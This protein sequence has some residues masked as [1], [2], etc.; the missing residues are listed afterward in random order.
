MGS[1][2]T[3]YDGMFSVREVPWHKHENAQVLS[4]YPSI[5]KARSI[6]HPWEPV[7]EE[8][9]RR[10]PY[11]ENGEPMS[12]FEKVE[13]FKLVSRSDNGLPLDAPPSD[14][15]LVLNKTLYEI[16]EAIEGEAKGSVQLETGGSL[17]AGKRVWLLMKLR[18]PITIEGDPNG[19]TVPFFGLQ[20]SHDR[21]GAFR[22]QGIATRIVCMNT[23]H[24]ADMEARA[25]GTE[26]AFSHVGDIHERIE[27][28]KAALGQWRQS[29]R[30]YQEHMEYLVE[31][32]LN[33]EQTNRFIEEF[34]KMPMAGAATDRVIANV[35][36]SRQAFR[37]ILGSQT[38]EGIN[39]TAYGVVQ[40]SVEYLNHARRSFTEE[41]RFTRN[42]LTRSSLVTTAVN[43]AT[44][45]GG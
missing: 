39:G 36:K 29:I 26:F 37:E 3:E 10:V 35:E 25:K 12:R 7:E 27:Q 6:A 15:P 20:S 2:M 5:E 24:M 9:F 11:I 40:A 1:G 44:K 14:Y 42:F 38:C 22:G 16:A 17:M 21:T 41:S 4:D 8:I 45:I 13:D 28:A 34:I 33:P 18:E 19:A 32:P 30:T 31:V 23:S 43:L